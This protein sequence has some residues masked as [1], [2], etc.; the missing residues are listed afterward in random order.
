[1]RLE[2]AKI[3]VIILLLLCGIMMA[4][5]KCVSARRLEL[6]GRQNNILFACAM[7]CLNPIN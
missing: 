5:K 4:V 3:V 6:D 2:G 7:L 1:M